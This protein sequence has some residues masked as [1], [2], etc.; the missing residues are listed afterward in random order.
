MGLFSGIVLVCVGFLEWILIGFA[1]GGFRWF[2]FVMGLGLGLPLR[3]VGIVGCYFY[4]ICGFNGWRGW[5]S[6]DF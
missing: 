4:F 2:E 6:L 5:C 1:I 3:V